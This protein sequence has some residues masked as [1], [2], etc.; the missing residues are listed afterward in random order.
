MESFAPENAGLVSELLSRRNK[1]SALDVESATLRESLLRAIE[2]SAGGKES[3]AC[4]KVPAAG[5]MESG[6][7]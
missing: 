5:L 2:S 7:N 1:E 3:F 6:V 4:G